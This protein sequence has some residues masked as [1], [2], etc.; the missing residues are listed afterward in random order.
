MRSQPVVICAM[1]QALTGVIALVHQAIL[2]LVYFFVGTVLN[3]HAQYHEIVY[4]LR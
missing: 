4:E 1:Q 3:K 2:I